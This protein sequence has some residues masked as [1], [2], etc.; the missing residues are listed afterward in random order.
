MLHEKLDKMSGLGVKI[1]DR[2]LCKNISWPEK[3]T[4]SYMINEPWSLSNFTLKRAWW[5]AQAAVDRR[6]DCC[7]LSRHRPDCSFQPGWP[8]L[9]CSFLSRCHLLATLLSYNSSWKVL[10]TL[11]TAVFS[12]DVDQTAV[13]YRS[14][15]TRLQFST[16]STANAGR[17]CRCPFLLR[18][19]SRPLKP[20]FWINPIK[21]CFFLSQLC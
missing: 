7:F 16:S 3:I 17:R 9:D 15:S 1:F 11:T 13:F 18:F 5:K 4:S 12:V 6:P 21:T 20:N 2:W 14:M 19:S 10:S 8:L